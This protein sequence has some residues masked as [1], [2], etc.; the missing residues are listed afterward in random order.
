ME[1]QRLNS[2]YQ[3]H[4]YS[5]WR[6]YY[7]SLSLDYDVPLRTVVELAQLLGHE[8]D[9]DALPIQLEIISG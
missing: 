1:Q 6:D 8:E 7:L 5:D 3:Q 4:G 9:F 2:I